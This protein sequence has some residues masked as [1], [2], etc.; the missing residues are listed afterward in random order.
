MLFTR[1]L[2]GLWVFSEETVS[3]SGWK[4]CYRCHSSGGAEAGGGQRGTV[5]QGEAAACAK[6]QKLAW[7]RVSMR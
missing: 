3:A 6:A 7:D 2:T 5:S 4:D 1:R